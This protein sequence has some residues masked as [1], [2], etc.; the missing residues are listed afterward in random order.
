MKRWRTAGAVTTAVAAIILTPIMLPIALYLHARDVKRMRALAHAYPCRKCGRLLGTGSL[1][2]ADEAWASYLA[3]VGHNSQGGVI[4]YRLVKTIDAICPH[5]GTQ[6][7]F[8]PN[9]RSFTP[10]RREDAPVGI[11]DLPHP[12]IA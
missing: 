5:C 12:P 4:R 9:D 11:E 6:Y 7:K 2:M 10:V 3:Q 8:V 1:R